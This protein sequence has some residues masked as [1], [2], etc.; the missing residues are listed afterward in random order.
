MIFLEIS[1]FW[2]HLKICPKKNVDENETDEQHSIGEKIGWGHLL[3]NGVRHNLEL[4]IYNK[5]R[6]LYSTCLQEEG[7][8]KWICAAAEKK[9]SRVA[10]LI[11]RSAVNRNGLRKKTHVKLHKRVKISFPFCFG[12]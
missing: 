7:S 6:T 2:Y 5:Y 10:N 1:W 9:D 3:E 8:L 4:D 12:C 11:E